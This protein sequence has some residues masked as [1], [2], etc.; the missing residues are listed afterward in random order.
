MTLPEKNPL[1]TE[2]A[3]SVFAAMPE[4]CLVADAQGNILYANPAT[5]RICQ[6]RPQDVIG[7]NVFGYTPTEPLVQAL[8]TGRPI[9]AQRRRLYNGPLEVEVYAYPL[10]REEMLSGAVAF[11]RELTPPPSLEAELAEERRSLSRLEAQARALAADGVPSFVAQSPAMKRAFE[12]GL[13]A[14]FAGG[15]LLIEGELGAGKTRLAQALHEAARA[16]RGPLFTVHSDKLT[17]EELGSLLELVGEGTLVLE[18]AADLSPALKTR[19]AYLSAADPKNGPL[20]IGTAR[21]R[22]TQ[23]ALA[24]R[25]LF[26]GRFVVAPP[27]RERPEDIILLAQAFLER[28]AR[29]QAKSIPGVNEEAA[30]L[31]LSYSW[32]GN[33]RELANV[34]E[35]AA[36]FGRDGEPL[37]RREIPLGEAPQSEDGPIFP[38]EELRRMMVSRAIEH[39][40]AGSEAKKEAARKLGISLATLYK[41]LR[42]GQRRSSP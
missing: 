2:L 1:L 18:E 17:E 6:R 34:I 14:A 9:I 28:F 32:P 42:A 25:R 15:P 19:L 27:L 33:V 39:Y 16:S 21:I 31:L 26:R 41:Y 22:P 5:G 24:L 37:T 4:P 7:T 35:R 23:R 11:F 3:T 20:V 12:E 36:L 10:F 38:L 29:E 30:S 13:K 8:K 40:G